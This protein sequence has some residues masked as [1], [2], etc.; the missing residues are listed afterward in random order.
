MIHGL[1]F[2]EYALFTQV[3]NNSSLQQQAQ[4]G[5]PQQ[6]Q[7]GIPQQQPMGYLGGKTALT[8]SGIFF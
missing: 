8:T 2:E 4:S 5:V 3:Y 7:F 1:L 6:Q